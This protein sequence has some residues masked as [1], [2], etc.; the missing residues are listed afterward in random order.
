M[1]EAML[2][3]ARSSCSKQDS[4][5]DYNRSFM[6]HLVMLS[7]IGGF[8]FGYDTGI[9]A[10]AVLYLKK[11]FPAIT[12]TQVEFVV[13]MAQFGAF[14]G[15]LCSSSLQDRYGRKPAIM[16]ADVA[17][18]AGAIFMAFA[19]TVEFLIFGRFIVGLG[20]GIASLVVPVYLSEISPV[21]IR[22][23]VVAVSIGFVTAGQLISSV[24]C[25]W[26]GDNWRLMF[27]LACVPSALQLFGMVGMPETQRW[28]A[29][30]GSMDRCRQVLKQVYTPDAVEHEM[31]ELSKEM[32]K[33]QKEITMTERERFADLFGPYWKCLSVGCMLQ[34]GQQLCGINTVMYYGPNVLKKTGINSNLVTNQ[35]ELVVLL[36]IPLAFVNAVG[37]S[38]ASIFVDSLGRR[39][40]LLRAIPGMVM[41]LCVVA[42]SMYLSNQTPGSIHAWGN[43]L[44]LVGL[45]SYLAFFSL[46]LA[47]TPW[48]VNTE[49]YPIH[50][51]GTA[52]SVATACNWA[53]N[54]VVSSSFLSIM[55][56]G[57]YG[58]VLA[59]LILAVFGVLTWIFVY[60]TLPETKGRQILVNVQNVMEGRLDAPL[61]LEDD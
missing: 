48:T 49:I 24:L 25:W 13:S 20:V 32:Q 46:G 33:M 18:T 56:I 43:G 36:N 26:L 37:T 51:I 17:F 27:G 10:G 14:I 35:N 22:G 15:S 5:G 16:L 54:F 31:D 57:S 30:N 53:S 60:R 40:M 52:T 11:D 7:S 61:T 41:S 12:T 44:A 1:D 34:F 21:K 28:L 45:F 47:T 19:R 38:S 39:F 8:L 9:V 6:I 29:R 58:N 59:F 55:E 23:T 2:Q 3:A 4:K 42:M 50:L